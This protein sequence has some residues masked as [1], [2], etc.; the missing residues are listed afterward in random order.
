[1][2]RIYKKLILHYQQLMSQNIKIINTTFTKIFK[3]NKKIME[4]IKKWIKLNWK[5]NPSEAHNIYISPIKICIKET[6]FPWI[7]SHKDKLILT[8]TIL[9]KVKLQE[10]IVSNN[11]IKK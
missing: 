11:T 6:S 8:W 4:G 7:S 5:S 3:P 1:M 9:T 10:I 2:M